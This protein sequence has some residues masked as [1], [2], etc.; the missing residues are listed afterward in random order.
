MLVVFVS[1]HE[2]ADRKLVLLD[3]VVINTVP[4]F[5]WQLNEWEVTLGLRSQTSNRAGLAG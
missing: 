2:P 5:S 3:H 1:L 4:D